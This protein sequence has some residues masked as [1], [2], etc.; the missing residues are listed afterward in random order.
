MPDEYYATIPRDD[1]ALGSLHHALAIH[2][3]SA[4]EAVLEKLA[5]IYGTDAAQR[6]R[7]AL[8]LGD[9]DNADFVELS[10]SGRAAAEYAGQGIAPYER[11]DIPPS[12][13][14]RKAR[15]Q[16]LIATA[17]ASR[18]SSG[19]LMPGYEY[20]WDAVEARGAIDF[21]G[22]LSV[23]GLQM[24]SNLSLPVIRNAVSLGALNLDAD[25]MVSAE[26][27]REWLAR[28]REFCPSRWFNLDD[29]QHP[30]DPDR[31]IKPDAKGMIS[32]PQT[33]EGDAFTPDRVVRPSRSTAGISISVGAK[34][35]EVQH[36]DFYDALAALAAM[37]VPRW[38]RRND[39]GNWGIVRARGA[40]T[41]V[42]K[43]EIDRQLAEKHEE[44]A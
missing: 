44:A 12:S 3:Q 29:D 33:A 35:E 7:Q 11:S 14:D 26:N 9:F 2:L 20:L 1:D 4:T 5:Y 40:W 21:G 24:L 23:V 16:A 13:A 41:A 43:A 15:V 10:H 28:R 27:A 37:R 31:V 22:K 25:G 36:Y 42:S 32:V 18:A 34:G 19:L 17:P 6:A 8:V 30:F 38:R 39:A